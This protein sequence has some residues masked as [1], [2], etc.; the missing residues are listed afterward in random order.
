MQQAARKAQLAII[1]ISS[2][3]ASDG[4]NH[5]RYIKL[6]TLYANRR[7]EGGDTPGPGLRSTGAFVFNTVGATISSP[8]S[9][10]GEALEG[11]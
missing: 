8:F 3:E 2:V 1:D 6:A 9:I 5:D 10:I 11:G 4:L 7:D